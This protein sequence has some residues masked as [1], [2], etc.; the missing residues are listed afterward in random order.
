MTE[1]GIPAANVMSLCSANSASYMSPVQSKSES[2][3]SL[4]AI[5]LAPRD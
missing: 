5:S 1:G 4:H 2:C 3:V